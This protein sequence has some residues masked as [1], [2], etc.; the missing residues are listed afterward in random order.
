[1]EVK[2]EATGTIRNTDRPIISINDPHDRRLSTHETVPINGSVIASGASHP[3][4][5]KINA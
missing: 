1:M 3:T 2:A 5:Q 4:I